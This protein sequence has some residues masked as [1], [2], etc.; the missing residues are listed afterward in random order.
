M[1]LQEIMGIIRMNLV[2]GVIGVL[3]ILVIFILGYFIIYKKLLGGKKKIDRRKFIVGSLLVLYIIMVTGVTFLN[4]GS[5][6][7]GETNLHFL[8]SYREAW[9][10]G[11]LRNWQMQIFNII[12]FMPLGFLLPLIDEKFQNIGRTFIVGLIFTILI[13]TIQYITGF[14]IF[15]LDDIFNNL[16]GAI[17]GYSIIMSILILVKSEKNKG[18]K[19][20][21]YI[22]PLILVVLIFSGTY[23]VYKNQEFGNLEINYDYRINMKNVE[24]IESLDLDK[25]NRKVPIYKAPKYDKELAHK[26]VV[27]SFK[28]MGIDTEDID[29]IQYSDNG[30][31]TIHGEP[32]YSIWLN[33]L[34]G[35]YTYADFSQHDEGIEA[36][37]VEEEKV[38]GELKKFN[39]DIP[40]KAKCTKSENGDYIWTVEKNASGDILLDGTVSCQYYDDNSIKE[41]NNSL[42]KYTKVREISIINEEQ[43]LNRIKEGRFKYF[44]E[45]I[46]KI[47]LID[48]KLDYHLDSKGYYQ[49]IYI[50]NAIVD[51]D[52]YDIAIPAML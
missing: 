44:N 23:I 37:N 47:E 34:D 45:D 40:K 16:V 41:I 2:L 21:K 46:N 20:I 1:R 12:M 48:I 32:G 8:S 4:R 5:F 50:F 14:G 26:F 7:K 38:I 29:I 36:L 13:E 9:N 10:S 39:I 30:V 33:Y 19:F 49:P 6:F 18:R 17:L 3:G 11:T 52:I 28:D 43:A 31:Y 22:S 42:V 51:G 15:E 27:E 25:S 35:S 24:I